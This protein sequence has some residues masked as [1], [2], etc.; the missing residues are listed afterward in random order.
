M[1]EVVATCTGGST[2]QVPLIMDVIAHSTQ[3]A[4]ATACEWLRSG[5]AAPA[6]TYEIRTSQRHGPAEDHVTN[7]AVGARRESIAPDLRA[8][9]TGAYDPL[10]LFRG[11]KVAAAHDFLHGMSG[12]RNWGGIEIY[13]TPEGIYV[14]ELTRITGPDGHCVQ[15]KHTAIGDAPQVVEGLLRSHSAEELLR[16]LRESNPQLFGNS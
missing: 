7:V 14:A 3:S 2:A 4:S 13:E 12:S 9:R 8:V 6:G 11:T 5:S 16:P 1:Y 10:L 15:R